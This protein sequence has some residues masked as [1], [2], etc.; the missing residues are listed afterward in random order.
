MSVH[1]NMY[2]SYILCTLYTDL[3]EISGWNTLFFKK[4]AKTF[5]LARASHDHSKK[6]SYQ[7]LSSICRPYQRPYPTI[8][9]MSIRPSFI[10]QN[11][12]CR[13]RQVEHVFETCFVIEFTLV[14]QCMLIGN[15]YHC[16]SAFGPCSITRTLSKKHS[17]PLSKKLNVL[18]ILN[19]I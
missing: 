9:F 19:L 18:K 7:V 12:Q 8:Q 17:D 16:N 1:V 2:C 11:F 13:I 6:S 3:R 4:T 14:R 10:D 5:R 15:H